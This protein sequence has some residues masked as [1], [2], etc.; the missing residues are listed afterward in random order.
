MGFEII[1]KTISTV[2]SLAVKVF[3]KKKDRVRLPQ[4]L[5]E[6][7]FHLI[8]TPYFN[9]MYF[10]LFFFLISPPLNDQLKVLILCFPSHYGY[11]YTYS[12][13]KLLQQKICSKLLEIIV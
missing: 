9:A 8:F 4:D 12:N 2:V 6:Y 7:E 10:L 1:M 3:K 13:E 5:V 11:T